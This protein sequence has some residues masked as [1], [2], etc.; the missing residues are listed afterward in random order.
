MILSANFQPIFPRV[1]TLSAAAPPMMCNLKLPDT[2][3]LDWTLS[4]C[5]F[6]DIAKSSFGNGSIIGVTANWKIDR[7]ENILLGPF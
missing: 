4:R 7:K 3:R 2:L 1:E 5:Y 6:P